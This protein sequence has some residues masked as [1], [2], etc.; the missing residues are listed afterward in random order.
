MLILLPPSA[1][2][3]LSSLACPSPDDCVL[4]FIG[5]SSLPAPAPAATLGA[6]R[7]ALDPAAVAEPG[8]P[9]ITGA[10]VT[11]PQEDGLA[12]P[13][14][15]PASAPPTA[16]LAADAAVLRTA[17]AGGGNAVTGGGAVSWVQSWR[18][19]EVA[20]EWELENEEERGGRG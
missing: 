7:A 18:K 1:S 3:C 2:P 15:V 16:D 5:D 6:A 9:A 19:A 17:V 20:G 11:S 10:E 13:L 12:D 8:T 4:A 14:A